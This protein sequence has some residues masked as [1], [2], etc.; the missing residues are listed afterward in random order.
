MRVC[1]QR[2]VQNMRARRT[3]LQLD[4]VRHNNVRQHGFQLVRGKES[5]GTDQTIKC[6][7]S[8]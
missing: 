3:I 4:V 5:S 7:N 1:C 6:V 2:R 8:S